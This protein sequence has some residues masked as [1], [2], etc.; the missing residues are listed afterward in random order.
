MNI[1]IKFLFI[2]ALLFSAPAFSQTVE[3]AADIYSLYNGSSQ[4]KDYVVLNN[5]LYFTAY[6]TSQRQIW[7]Y[8]GT[9]ASMMPLKIT[10]NYDAIY[11]PLF[12]YNN[13]MYFAAKEAQNQMFNS[14]FKSDG[15]TNGTEYLLDSSGRRMFEVMNA[16]TFKN[17]LYFDGAIIGVGE[18]GKE[19]FVTDGTKAGTYIVKDISIAGSSNPTHFIEYNN[20]MYFFA[21]D[22]IHGQELWVSDGTN[23]GTQMVKDIN[24]NGDFLIPANVQ[25][26]ETKMF[27]FNQKLYIVGS[28]NSGYALYVTDGTELNT[29]KAPAAMNEIAQSSNTNFVVSQNKL[30]FNYTGTGLGI[31]TDGSVAGTS[32]LKA[33]MSYPTNFYE[34]KSKVYFASKNDNSI[35]TELWVTDGTDTGTSMVKD[36]DTASNVST[37]PKDFYE[38]RNKLYFTATGPNSGRDLWMTDG[39]TTGTTKVP[40]LGATNNNGWPDNPF[41]PIAF[42]GGLYFTAEFNNKG[43]ELWRIGIPA[44]INTMNTTSHDFTLYPNPGSGSF[45]IDLGVD[46]INVSLEIKDIQGKII[47]SAEYTKTNKINYAIEGVSGIYFITLTTADG[48]QARMKVVKE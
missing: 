25:Y 40:I 1:K 44:G 8:D 2:V 24:P 13:S 11:A 23:A 35:G 32:V 17:K 48:K 3:L 4:P 33:N 34:Y 30:F 19:L 14:F 43:S 20:K 18:V 37:W 39:T 21:D 7:Q 5:R 38:Y 16:F 45:T 27:V 26:H 46:F 47:Q 15:T 29:V 6:G 9:N 28:D 10:G 31:S 42:G 12:T 41:R 36:L 22:G